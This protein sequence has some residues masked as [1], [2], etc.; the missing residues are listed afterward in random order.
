MDIGKEAFFANGKV[1]SI[2]FGGTTSEWKAITKGKDWNYNVGNYYADNYTVICT[3][4]TLTKEESME[5]L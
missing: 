4:G 2:V 5:S 1:K 3:D